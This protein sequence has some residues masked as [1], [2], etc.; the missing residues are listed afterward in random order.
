[1]GSVVVTVE[2]AAIAM[3]RHEAVR[4]PHRGAARVLAVRDRV[5]DRLLQE[6]FQLVASLRVNQSTD[7]LHAAAASHTTDGRLGDAMDRLLR[8]AARLLDSMLGADA[9]NLQVIE[10]CQRLFL[11]ASVSCLQ[12]PYARIYN[13]S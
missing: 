13:S 11:P 1:M 5:V 10:V 7:T 9:L 3:Q 6:V 2:A 12:R 8:Q 4:G